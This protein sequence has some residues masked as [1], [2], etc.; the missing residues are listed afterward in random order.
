VFSEQI[1]CLGTPPLEYI[2]LG[3]QQEEASALS[4]VRTLHTKMQSRPKR[5]FAALSSEN[6]M[7]NLK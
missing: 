3:L 6:Q 2:S 4:N 7:A 5:G 1:I